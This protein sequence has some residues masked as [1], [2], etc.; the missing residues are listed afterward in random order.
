MPP[1][2][3]ELRRDLERA[4]IR[5]RDIA[6]EGA[7]ASLA[8]LSVGAP[9]A[10]SALS[11][12]ERD[13]R[14]ALR[15]RG[16]SLGGGSVGGGMDGLA[17]EVAYEQWHRM[18]FARFLA[19]NELLIHPGGAPVLLADVA[20]LAAEE[21][22]A[23][24]WVL[25]ARYAATMLPGIFRADDP[26]HQIRFAPEHR[27]RLEA[28]LSELPAALFR[29]DDS[30]GWVY[31]FWQ[32]K[33]KK[34][35]NESGRKIGGTDLPPVTQLFTEHYMVRFLLENSLGAWWSARHPASP[36]IR[37]WE[38]LRFRDDGAPAAGTFEGWPTRAAEITVMDPCM[39]SGHFLVA[40]AAMLRGMRMEEER[41]DASAAALAVLRDN[42][43]GLELDARCTQLAA[44]ALAFDAWKAGGYQPLP[45]PNI[46]CT[47]IAIKGQLDDWR[48]LAG[49]DTNMAS[50]L[51]RLYALFQ[52]APELGSLIDPTAV[53]G[54]GIWRADP[55]QLLAKLDE[56]LAKETGDPAAA[57][58][59]ASAEGTTT[60]ARL[61][62]RRYWLVTT[63][64]PFLGRGKQ[65]ETLRGTSDEFYRHARA[66]LA[67]TLQWRAQTLL[68]PTGCY[69]GVCPETWLILGRYRNM[70]HT[71]LANQRVSLVAYLG[72]G[73][74]GQ[75]GGAVV[76]VGL[77]ISGHVAPARTDSVGIVRADGR[78]SVEMKIA[79]LLNGPIAWVPQSQIATDSEARIVA[80]ALSETTQ[81]SD[82]AD[83]LGGITTG[84]AARLRREFFELA[85]LGRWRLAQTTPRQTG[86]YE[87]REIAIYWD[88]GHGLVT[89]AE[90]G[91]ATIA[92]RAAWGRDGVGIRATD[93]L[94]ATIYKGD[95]FENICA[96]LLP[97][98]ETDLPAIWAFCSSPE[99]RR[100]VRNVD[101]TLRVTN[102]TL[103]KVPFDLEHWTTVA[104][105][106]YPNGLPE[107]DSDDPTQWLFRGTIVGSTAP[108]H[109]A[110]ARLLGYRWPQ[111][112]P[113]ELDELADQDGIVPLPSALGEATASERLRALLATAYGSD[114]SP[115]LLDR[116]LADAGS[117]GATLESWL[118]DDFF[119]QHA[120]LFR[121]RPFIWHVWDGLKDG[122]SALLHYHRL[123]TKALEKLTY[124]YL[125]DWIE[126]QRAL[127]Q[128]AAAEARLVAALRL[129]E[130]LTL[131]LGGEPPYDI[132][133]RW[134]AL[135][136]QPVGWA[137][138]LDDGVRLNIRPFVTAAILRSRFTINWNKD[139]GTNP[140]G[141]ER[142]ND[143][144]YSRAQKLAEKQTKQ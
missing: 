91:G 43:F 28:V 68:E 7:R 97:R 86:D 16:R 50:A 117:P 121:N 3:P 22:E 69:A 94:D 113:D 66:D 116:L 62:S 33:R 76:R 135:T 71:V 6:E 139:R 131:I 41:I 140:D 36:L 59:G 105:E 14:T 127:H 10:P 60:A 37:E 79:E 102:A 55:D 99:F 20:D 32:A 81:L 13:L 114:W 115:R 130:K 25:A 45:V 122:F 84:D 38:Y 18:L 80:R 98:R 52:D 9:S 123:D 30:L 119:A 47:G 110:V 8:V 51:E 78:R 87:G 82:F 74:F 112:V 109:V 88:D 4:V 61:L 143:L 15:A 118:R 64:P 90:G 72:S 134:K 54:E 83:G 104:A 107:P 65:R 120:R 96:V 92:G 21:G 42:L 125:N 73:A 93:T 108:L 58:F 89:Q 75:I 144:H 142:L 124:T 56:A 29:A 5:A 27:T 133:V 137:P 100:V 136:Q 57:V 70:R 95:I 53:A 26:A 141:S 34:E 101:S 11:Q 46:A 126:R 2:S 35:V 49:T 85:A 138:D 40:A 17:E 67:T 129:Q 103:V 128:E 106:R 1:L 132:Y 48:R 19:E 12:A 111:Q 24:L 31:Q 77:F 44:F 23:D 39:G 63:N